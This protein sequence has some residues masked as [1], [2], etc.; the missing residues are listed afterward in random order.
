MKRL[1]TP[2]KGE[3]I[4]NLNGGT[5]T[6]RVL[7]NVKNT[8]ALMRELSAKYHND[9]AP[10][11]HLSFVQYYDFIKNIPYTADPKKIEFL[12][13]PYYTLYQRGNGGDCDDKC[14]CIGAYCSIA[15]I[16]FRFVALGKTKDGR[17]HHVITEVLMDAPG[18]AKQWVHIDPT[19]SFNTIGKQTHFYPKRLVISDPYPKLTGTYKG[20]FNERSAIS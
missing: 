5:V 3:R 19:Y 15:K 13:R 14:I 17:L 6:V 10:F 16:P 18:Q 20:T 4:R 2:Q 9:V 11:C 1:I 8:G 7:K 12:Q